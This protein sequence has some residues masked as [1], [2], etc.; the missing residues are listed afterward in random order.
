MKVYGN[1]MKQEAIARLKLLKI[2]DNVIKEFEEGVLNY[3]ER[4]SKDFDGILYWVNNEETYAKAVKDFEHEY[5]G[6]VYHAQLTHSDFGDLL[7]LL[8]V[9]KDSE[10][11]DNDRKELA[12]GEALAYVVNLTEPM[13]SELGYIGIV[14]KNGGVSRTY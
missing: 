11:W 4:L 7:S 5:G 2:S 9:G 10:L 8:Y 3:S 1:N 12:E 6:L 13:F 14:P